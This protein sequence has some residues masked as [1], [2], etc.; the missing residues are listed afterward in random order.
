MAS[1]T[2]WTWVS[3]NPG[4]W[5]W[6]GRPGVLQSMGSKRVGHDWVTKLNWTLTLLVISFYLISL[7]A[8]SNATN[9][10]SLSL[11]STSH[12]I[13]I[14]IFKILLNKFTLKSNRQLNVN[15][16]KNECSVFPHRPLPKASPI[17]HTHFFLSQFMATQLSGQKSLKLSLI[18]LLILKLILKSLP[19]KYIWNLSTFYYF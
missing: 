14:R 1:L 6:T 7:N 3:V 11:A 17:P 19:S 4:S 16:C 8:N 12:P 13:S 10:P 18:M 15:L 9:S 2:Q 5:W